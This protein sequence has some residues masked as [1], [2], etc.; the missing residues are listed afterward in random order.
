MINLPQDASDIGGHMSALLR[1]K[2]HNLQFIET[3]MKGAKMFKN[4]EASSRMFGRTAP[5]SIMYIVVII[6]DVVC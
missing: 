4:D 5:S 3:V 2:D 1:I 6:V